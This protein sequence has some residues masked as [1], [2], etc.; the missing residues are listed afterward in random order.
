[1]PVER[2]AVGDD[3]LVR[4]GE[5]IPVDGVITSPVAVLDEA[6]VTGEPISVNRQAGELARS[7]TL[8]AGETFELRASTTAGESTYA[9]IVR[10]VTA[11]A[12]H[13]DNSWWGSH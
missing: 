7:G 10:M 1:M 13:A 9:G 11:V 6:A 4:A 12:G 8:N 3:L 2:V 5:V